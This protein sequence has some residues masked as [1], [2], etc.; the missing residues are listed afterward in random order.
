[1]VNS[2]G[3]RDEGSEECGGV[4]PACEERQERGTTEMAGTGVKETMRV[5]GRAVRQDNAFT[6]VAGQ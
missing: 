3:G 1:M 5:T 2:G 4:R 6:R